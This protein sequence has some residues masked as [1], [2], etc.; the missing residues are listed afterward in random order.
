MTKQTIKRIINFVAFIAVIASSALVLIAKLIPAIT[1]VLLMIA[2]V[3]CFLVCV[4]AGGYFAFSRR[5]GVY[6]ALLVMSILIAGVA[7][8]IF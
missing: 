3:I 8:I 6:I 7:L 2:G 5:N 4:F 1:D